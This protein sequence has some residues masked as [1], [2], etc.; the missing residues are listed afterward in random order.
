MK[1]TFLTTVV[2][3]LS[4]LSSPGNPASPLKPV[5]AVASSQM[6]QHPAANAIDGNVSD[7]SRWVSEASTSPAWIVVD[8]G[9]VH[10]L[11]GVHLF[12]GFGA[13]GPLEAFKIQFWSA[14]KWID[15]PS[16]EISGNAAV[17]LAIPFDQTVSVET[18]KIRVWITA[19]H[20]DIARLKEIVIWPSGGGDLPR[21]PEAATGPGSS[22]QS[23]IV[24]IYLNQSGFNLGKPK[25]FTAPTLPD[26]TRFIVRLQKGGPAL[27]DGI[28]T[29][30]IGD[31]SSF[32][33][34]A[35]D[36]YV[37]EAGGLVSV[38]FRVG[39]FWLERVT[40]QDA[41]DFMIDSRH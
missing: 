4:F 6:A 12:S 7:D 13:G 1:S 36:E 26:G 27:A 35:D 40:Y 23:D 16:A 10:K 37:V 39:P 33:P 34:Q 25:R 29:Q 31:F 5:S 21:L 9:A 28:I 22:A 14:E 8:L 15:I 24:P 11:A 18:D 38:P 20:Q 2:L 19:S 30:N 3:V 41:V 32:N 17:A